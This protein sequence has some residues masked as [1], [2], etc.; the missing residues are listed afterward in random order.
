MT[1]LTLSLTS[2]L[3]LAGTSTGHIHIYDTASHQLLRTLSAHKGMCI[4]HLSTMLRP[5]DLVGHISLSLSVGTGAGAGSDVKDGMPVKH[6]APFQRMRDAKAREAHEVTMIL[7]AHSSVSKPL[8]IVKTSSQFICRGILIYPSPN[9]TQTKTNSVLSY[10]REELI[11]DHA[12]FVHT[13]SSGDAS[14]GGL[15]GVSLQ[16]RVTELEG[17]VTR[18]REQLG[19]AKGVNDAM[20]ESV[21]QRLVAEGK[22]KE[23]GKEKSKTSEQGG[24]ERP[25]EGMEVDQQDEEGRESG[26]RRKRGRT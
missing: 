11:R 26:K 23:K 20:W 8:S 19:K 6:V 2:S 21:V 7:P 17:E 10:S 14:S 24:A 3:L 13:P 9:N 15:T 5:P 18:L 1:A 22:E 16:T 12:F 25:E 4:T